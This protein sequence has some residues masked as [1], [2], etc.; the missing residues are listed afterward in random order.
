[1]T[2]L[3]T[4]FVH[5]D[6]EGFLHAAGGWARHLGDGRRACLGGGRR[7]RRRVDYNSR[8]SLRCGFRFRFGL[9]FG[10]GIRLS[11]G[12]RLRSRVGFSSRKGRGVSRDGDGDIL[13]VRHR[14]CVDAGECAVRIPELE[15]VGRV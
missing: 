15:R 7:L 10:R 8:R 3:D 2:D 14:K 11:R 1:M 13:R 6:G 4:A 12:I 5:G 9:S